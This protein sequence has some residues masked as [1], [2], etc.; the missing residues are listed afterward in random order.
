MAP[1]PEPA[2]DP[3]L[4]LTRLALTRRG[5]LAVQI[6]L[7]A[8]TEHETH[9]ALPVT[10]IAAIV[11]AALLADAIESARL[12]R[13]PPTSRTV[14]AHGILDLGLITALLAVSGGA[15]NPLAS[16][17]L[18]EVAL[19]AMVL[20]ARAAWGSTGL[21]I[22][23][24][25]AVVLT[26]ADLPGLDEEPHLHPEHL[27]GHIVAFD[28]AAIAITAFVGNLAGALRARD[29]ALRASEADRAQA[30]RLAALGTLAAGTAHAL[31]TPLGAMEL[32][33]EEA[34]LD[35]PEQAEGQASLRTL[36]AEVR[37]C[38]AILDRMLA[39]EDG[40]E[41][42]TD[43]LFDRLREWVDDW[44]AAQGDPSPVTLVL[45]EGDARVRGPGA[46]WRD[47]LWTVLD[48]ARKA[49]G[50][51]EITA[52]RVDGGRIGVQVRDHGSP[53]AP[54]ALARIG[55]PFYTAWPSGGGTGLGTYVAR[56]Q[57]RE[58]GGDL[59]LAAADPGVVA[60]LWMVEER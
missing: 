40:A 9:V 16:F 30:E 27:V 24:Q 11:G 42:A 29:Q 34:A 53:I 13:S 22:L 50:A 6:L 18:V 54:E 25:A 8:L 1:L 4:A 23:S 19:L 45:P 21:A 14:V 51:I 47:A 56:R 36:R 32:L 44:R 52:A 57:A 10:P 3:G 58:A 46:G 38:R 55:E 31:A 43:G 28:L 5:L 20:P 12:R 37:R 59:T 33:A 49:G 17:Y 2:D 39:G 15:E 7:I 60:T 35:L 26:A 48:N 41:E